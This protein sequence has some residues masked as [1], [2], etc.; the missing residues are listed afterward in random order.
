[1]A[2][3]TRMDAAA[4]QRAASEC[5]RWSDRSL[6]VAWALLVEGNPLSDVAAANEMKPQQANVIRARFVEKAKQARL[7]EFMKQETPKQLSVALE[8]F[9]ADMSTLRDKG[10]SVDQIV[11]Y[12]ADNGVQASATTVRSFMRN[13]RA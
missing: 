4:F 11:G 1:M 5:K 9:A 10:Y 3:P 2:N 13:N 7:K 12:L 8:P 6:G